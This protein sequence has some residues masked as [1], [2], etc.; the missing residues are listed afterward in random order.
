MHPS[1][2]GFIFSISGPAPSDLL[3]DQAK[4]FVS[5]KVNSSLNVLHCRCV[6]YVRCIST[7]SARSGGINSRNAGTPLSPSR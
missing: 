1:L 4:I 3:D 6:N 7:L 2:L 5:R